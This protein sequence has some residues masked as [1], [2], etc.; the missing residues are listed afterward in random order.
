LIGL[1]SNVVIRYLVQ[2][3]AKQSARATTFMERELSADEPGLLTHV[4]L[5]EIVWVLEDCYALARA[6]ISEV[7]EGLF[8]AKQIALEDAQLAWQALRQ[9]DANTA[10]FSDALI[11]LVAQQLGCPRTVTFDKNAAK[12][13]QFALLR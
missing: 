2:D 1:D 8:T 4:V 12:L 6:Q 9:F 11:G 5:C 13:P 7:L 10:D 3:D